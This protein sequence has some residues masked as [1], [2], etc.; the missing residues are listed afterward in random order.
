M[1]TITGD[2]TMDSAE[3][4]GALADKWRWI[5]ACLLVFALL[6]YP[7]VRWVTSTTAPGAPPAATAPPDLLALSLQYYQ[8]KRY[9]EAVAASKAFLEINPKSA[10]AWNNLGVSYA[11][12]GQWAQAVASLEVALRL[13][14]DHQLAKNNL[15]WVTGEMRTISPQRKT[16]EDYLNQSAAQFRANKF[17]EALAS[18]RQCLNLR[19]DDADAYNNMAVSYIR[20]LR[21]DEAVHSAQTALRLRPDFALARNNLLWA[22]AETRNASRPAPG[23]R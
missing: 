5:G 6:M 11:G 23:N 1:K 7:I 16:A 14:P 10:D 20:L 17:D 21:Y 12:L 4:I 18:A 15:A 13:N 22:L 3:S 19:P 8:A 9:T 2:K